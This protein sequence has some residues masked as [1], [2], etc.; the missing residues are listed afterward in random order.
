MPPN[1]LV[2]SKA[3]LYVRVSSK[4][5]EHVGSIPAQCILLRSYARRHGYQIVREFIDA[6]T[7]TGTGAAA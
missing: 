5:Q 4:E 2:S 7:A 3:I 1:A 6:S